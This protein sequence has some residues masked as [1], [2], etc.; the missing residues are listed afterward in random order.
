MLKFEHIPLKSVYSDHRQS[1][2]H[3]IVRDR[4]SVDLSGNLSGRLSIPLQR[5]GFGCTKPENILKICI[6]FGTLLCILAPLTESLD[7]PAV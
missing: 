1:K 5:W 6:Q 3:N 7:S 4:I 2:P